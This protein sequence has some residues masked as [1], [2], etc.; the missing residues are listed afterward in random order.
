MTSRQINIVLGANGEGTLSCQGL[1]EF[2]CLGNGETRYPANVTNQG[3][4]GEEK[5][6]ELYSNELDA[7]IEQAILLGWEY[8]LFIHAGADNLQDNG[9]PT[10]G[11]IQLAQPAAKQLYDWL[12]GPVQILIQKQP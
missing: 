11:N 12:D 8:G 1:G 10:S 7:N 4:E 3:T 6:P 5:F 9:G 2:P